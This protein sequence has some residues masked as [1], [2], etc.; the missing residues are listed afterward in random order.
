[1]AAIT[2]PIAAQDNSTD[3]PSRPDSTISR[4][5]SLGLGRVAGS[6]MATKITTPVAMMP[7]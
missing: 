4:K 3:S 1:M 7:E 5:P 2:I 6:R